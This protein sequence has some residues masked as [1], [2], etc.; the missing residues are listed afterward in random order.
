[1]KVNQL[2]LIQGSYAIGGGD[3]VVANEKTSIEMLG[4]GNFLIDL[5]GSKLIY[6]PA[7]QVKFALCERDDKKK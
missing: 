7:S 2:R 4:G 5:S 1:M 6:I 3:I